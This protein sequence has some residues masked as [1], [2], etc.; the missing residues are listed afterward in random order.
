METLGAALAFLRN[1]HEVAFSGGASPFNSVEHA[2]LSKRGGQVA[3]GLRK[4]FLEP[5]E[6]S[7]SQR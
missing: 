2:H 4:V 5:S 7:A 1:F 3:G 6:L